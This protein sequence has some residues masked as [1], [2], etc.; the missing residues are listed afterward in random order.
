MLTNRQEKLL[1]IIVESYIKTAKPVGSKAICEKLN[2]SSATIRNEMVALE[3]LG[4]LEKTHTSSGRIPSDK[5]YR[6]YVDN[7]MVPKE[8]TGED[9]LKLKQIFSNNARRL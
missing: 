9:I 7:I 2:C 3:N 6:Y 1:K 5:G 8:L 4:L